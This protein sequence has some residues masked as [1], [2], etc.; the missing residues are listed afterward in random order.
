MNILKSLSK[1]EIELL[2][3]IGIE[4]FDKKYEKAEIKEIEQSIYNR[5][6]LDTKITYADAERYRQIYERFKYLTRID[7]EKVQ[8]YTRKEFEEDYYLCTVIM[9]GAVWNSPN[10]I[11]K[12]REARNKNPLTEEEKMKYQE[13]YEEN[14]KK[15]SE[16]TKKLEEKYGGELSMVERYYSTIEK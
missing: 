3:N 4:I 10:R 9:H 14:S 16:Y 11:N 6:Y 1:E 7:L 8:K 5:E 12:I 13:K 15:L 2:K